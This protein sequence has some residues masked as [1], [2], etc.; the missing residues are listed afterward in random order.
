MY[1]DIF[2]RPGFA[3]G[4][5]VGVTPQELSRE[6]MSG[7]PP[8]TGAFS[9]A[10]MTMNPEA[11]QNAQAQ[12]QK[13]NPAQIMQRMNN[14]AQAGNLAGMGRMGDSTLVHM[15]PREVAGL[16]ALANMH[17]RN[18]ST[19]PQTGLPE[20][21][22]IGDLLG[23]VLPMALMFVPGMQWAAPLASAG[24]TYA[25]TGDLG[26]AAL[27]GVGSYGLG[28]LGGAIAAQAGTQAATQGLGQLA[29]DATADI[30]A[31]GVA[32]AATTS[33]SQGIQGTL[34]AEA[35]NPAA[36]QSMANA[37]SP[38]GMAASINPIPN[39]VPTPTPTPTPQ[40]NLSAPAAGGAVTGVNPVAT[41]NMANAISPPGMAAKIPTPFQPTTVNQGQF[42]TNI[43][44]QAGTAGNVG[45]TDQWMGSG[46]F[47]DDVDPVAKVAQGQT[48]TK[49]LFGDLLAGPQKQFGDTVS[50]FKNIS[51][52][53]GGWK[54][55]FNQT[56]GDNMFS[57][58]TNAIMGVGGT[59]GAM[60]WPGKD[61][62]TDTGGS[63]IS[64]RQ[65]DAYKQAGADRFNPDRLRDKT[66]YQPEPYARTGERIAYPIQPY[67]IPSPNPL[68]PYTRPYAEGGLA[69]MKHLSPIPGG[70]R[71]KKSYRSAKAM[72][73]AMYPTKQD[74]VKAMKDPESVLA[75]LGITSPNDPLLYHAY[76]QAF[77]EGDGDGSSDSIPA[78]IN[79]K[80]PAALSDGEVVVP[81]DVVSHLG[82]GSSQAGAK[83]LV[84]MFDDVRKSKGAKKGLPPR[85]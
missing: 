47:M 52:S 7:G 39:A 61:E 71:P 12:M 68:D 59:L 27:S 14:R 32:D 62:G 55:F 38:P 54:D 18:L 83:R 24:M 63:G 43:A 70:K 51:N 79:G 34:G 40:P 13:P 45:R 15:Q 3:N 8:R 22:G 65:A 37:I 66:V 53:E 80:A 20:A 44:N 36:T 33:A 26:A 21:F 72:I 82:N 10:P 23:S 19:N 16:Q 48:A 31:K 6:V 42:G 58:K 78:S 5:A 60:M 77:V 29:G 1:Q 17:G 73:K 76:R 85:I 84:T 9:S 57:N 81:A 74:A 2:Y 4:G 75:K 30:A 56:H 46:G 67:P 25:R 49:G 28:Q 64:K 50:G 41:Q 11:L 69:S 35:F